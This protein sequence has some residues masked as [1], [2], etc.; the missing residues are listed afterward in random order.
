[1]N[2]AQLAAGLETPEGFQRLFEVNGLLE[3]IFQKI[4]SRIMG[5]K[6][7]L[8][9]DIYSSASTRGVYENHTLHTW[10]H[11]NHHYAVMAFS[12]SG[13][14]DAKI[15]AE[16][17]SSASSLPLDLVRYESLGYLRLEP[18]RGGAGSLADK[19]REI[20]SLGKDY[21]GV[22]VFPVATNNVQALDCPLIIYA[23]KD[24]EHHIY[25]VP[26]QKLR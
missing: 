13:P 4:V 3:S 16:L 21:K 5:D 8:S 14:L 22:L 26:A 18:W 12:S 25:P 9:F 15:L 7:K 6:A 20:T 10:Q 19:S 23:L 2:A 17:K 11:E 24:G 1:M